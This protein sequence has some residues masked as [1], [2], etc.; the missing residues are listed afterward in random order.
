LVLIFVAGETP[1]LTLPSIQP[2]VDLASACDIRYCSEAG[3][4]NTLVNGEIWTTHVVQSCSIQRCG[5]IQRF[6]WS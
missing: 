2:G 5:S 1:F 4:F 6:C 3:E